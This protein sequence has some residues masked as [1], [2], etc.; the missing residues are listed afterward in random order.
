MRTSVVAKRGEMDSI[1]PNRTG[2]LPKVEGEEALGVDS[3][4]LIVAEWAERLG[5]K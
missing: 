5:V 3:W 4:A 1:T 2:D